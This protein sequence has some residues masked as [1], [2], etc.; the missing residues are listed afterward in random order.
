MTAC[1]FPTAQLKQ[2]QN[3]KSEKLLNAF[4]WYNPIVKVQGLSFQ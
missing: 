4:T 1:P 3:P 2:I